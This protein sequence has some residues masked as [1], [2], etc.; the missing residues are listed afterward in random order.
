MDQIFYSQI[1]S[2]L[3]HPRLSIYYNIGSSHS[4]MK[5]TDIET[6]KLTY[7]QLHN[8]TRLDFYP[9]IGRK[10]GKFFYF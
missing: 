10:S 1:Y 9:Y 2:N 7:N 6:Y 4:L 5:S 3:F 8:V